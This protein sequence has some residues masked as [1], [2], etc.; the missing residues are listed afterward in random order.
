MSLRELGVDIDVDVEYL[1]IQRADQAVDELVD[2]LKQLDRTFRIN[3]ELNDSGARQSIRDLEL[4]LQQLDNS[5][6]NI[7]ADVSGATAEI[8]HIRTQIEA[9]DNHTINIDIDTAAAHAQ[10]VALQAQA[11]SVSGRNIP[12]PGIPHLPNP[13]KLAGLF[14]IGSLIKIGVIISSIILFGPLLAS[15]LMVLVGVIGTVGVAIGVLAGGLLA[16]SS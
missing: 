5:N 13:G 15:T 1:Q 7:N 10:L 14:N 6:I 9:I 16:L 2:S 12:N 11:S 4:Q 8:A 3:V